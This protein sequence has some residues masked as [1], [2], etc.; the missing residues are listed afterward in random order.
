MGAP[1][2]QTSRM[3]RIF[4][5]AAAAIALTALTG[6]GSSKDAKTVGWPARC[7]SAKSMASV[8]RTPLV[9]MKR[10]SW[11][12]IYDSRNPKRPPNMWVHRLPRPGKGG[13]PLPTIRQHMAGS[14]QRVTPLPGLGRGAFEAGFQARFGPACWVGFQDGAD[15]AVV[16]L[17]VRAQQQPRTVQPPCAAAARVAE[18]FRKPL[19]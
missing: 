7:P 13:L 10:D 1:V 6:C 9:A 17:T 5:I 16:E 2:R 14:G 12:C 11:S 15:T 19:P 3:V 4:P 8:T 18:V